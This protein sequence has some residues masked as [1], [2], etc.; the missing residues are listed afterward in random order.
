MDEKSKLH[1]SGSFCCSDS[2][3]SPLMM[4]YDGI[5]KRVQKM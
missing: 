4:T 2:R 3:L 1:F 5:D